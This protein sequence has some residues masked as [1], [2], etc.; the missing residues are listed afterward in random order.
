M[1]CKRVVATPGPFSH[2]TPSNIHQ[3][4]IQYLKSTKP[5][6]YTW[7]IK[8]AINNSLNPKITCCCSLAHF[9][10][11]WTSTYVPW[12]RDS[13]C[14]NSEWKKRH[15]T[16][17]TFLFMGR[18]NPN[19]VGF[20]RKTIE[21]KEEYRVVFTILTERFCVRKMVENS[22]ELG[23]VILQLMEVCKTMD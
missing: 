2:D 16:L 21:S 11:D 8:S 9:R 10:Q 13:A 20:F 5:E 19:C 1:L 15:E 12:L 18:G 23:K 4:T 7:S 14:Q 22:E 6:W 17:I 3:Y